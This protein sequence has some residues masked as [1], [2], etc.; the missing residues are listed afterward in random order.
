MT[1]G[2]VIIL[3]IA[4]ASAAETTPADGG[5]LFAEHCAACHGASAKGNGTEGAGLPK[6]PADLTKISARRG[7]VWPML[8]VMSIID[9]YTKRYTPREYMPVI[10]EISE[11]PLVSFDTGNGLDTPVPERLIALVNFLESIQSPRPKR[12][13]P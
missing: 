8:E 1:I 12:Y 5:R 11:G 9:G 3:A 4:A 13:V 10:E 6:Q 2:V 7:D